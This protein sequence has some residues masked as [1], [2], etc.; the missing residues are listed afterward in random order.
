MGVL[1]VVAALVAATAV[2]RRSH[3]SDGGLGPGLGCLLAGGVVLTLLV[4]TWAVVITLGGAHL[5]LDV[6]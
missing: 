1:G 6:P 5:G 3:R 2:W 4:C